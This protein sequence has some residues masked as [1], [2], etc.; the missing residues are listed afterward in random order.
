MRILLIVL[1][2]FLGSVEASASTINFSGIAS[3][4]SGVAPLSV[5]FDATG[6][7]DIG[8]T[9]PFHDLEYKWTFGDPA[10]GVTWAYGSNAGHNSK[11]EA[12]GPVAAHV[13]ETPGTYT[14][15]ATVTDGAN[16]VSNS[17][18]VTVT[19]PNKVFSGN[20]TICIAATTEPVAGAGGCPTGA[21]VHQQISFPSAI[22]NYALTGKRILFKRGDTFINESV[23]TLLR[24]GPGIIGA[25]GPG[26]NPIIQATG[27]TK[28]LSLS[29]PKTPNISDWRI[30]D[31]EFDGLSG[32]KAQGV[33]GGGGINQVLLLR[34]NIHNMNNGIQFAITALDYL[35]AHGSFG[36]EIWDQVS[37]VD[38][39]IS[40]ATPGNAGYGIFLSASRFALLGT[41]VSDTRASPNG[42]VM[43][44][45]YLNKAILSNNTLQLQPPNGHVLKLHGPSWCTGTVSS[46]C[47]YL[48]DQPPTGIASSGYTEYVAIGD[49]KFISGPGAAYTVALEPQNTHSDER[50]RNIIVERNWFV[51]S[52]GTQIALFMDGSEFTLRNNICDMTGANSQASVKR[53]CFGMVTPA[54]DSTPPSNNIK[55][56]NNTAFESDQ[57]GANSTFSLATV[58]SATTN[59]TV[60][61][62]LAYAPLAPKTAIIYGTPGAGLIT[63]NNSTEFQIK[64]T[65]PLFTTN[66]P[67]IPSDFKPTKGSYAIGSGAV[68]PIWSDFFQIA[69]PATRDIGAIIH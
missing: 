16:Q 42:H 40:N 57:G 68:V 36:H 56:Y 28:I 27:N 52:G 51:A 47:N 61:N 4:T 35:N 66:T 43:R 34:M 7:T 2:S 3:R 17:Y 64:N 12:M 58:G 62:N 13:F 15:T 25:Y 63:S 45:H 14:V 23:A 6:T 44:S 69:E 30:M 10:S 41:L 38:S 39:S 49:N 8:T 20:N 24:T 60:V 67:M 22:D 59:L 31:L 19:D 46:P 11:N 26:A 29:S 5:F 21:E 33:V 1:F 55:I 54:T 50:L 37:I 65:A 32:S 9:R 18:I 48:T 53:T